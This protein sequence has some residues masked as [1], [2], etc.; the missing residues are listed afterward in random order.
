MNILK[1][2]R[3]VGNRM[4]KALF[5]I[6]NA[7]INVLFGSFKIARMIDIYCNEH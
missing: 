3:K 4:N 6:F 1:T 7:I 2:I 5:K